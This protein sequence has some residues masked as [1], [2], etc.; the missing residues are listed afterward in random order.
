MAKK[1]GKSAVTLPS[2]EELQEL[3]LRAIVAY[4]VRAGRRVQPLFELPDKSPNRLQHMLAIDR[5]LATT[6]AFVTDQG[7]VAVEAAYAAAMDASEVDERRKGAVA[8]AF[9]VAKAAAAAVDSLLAT[10]AAAQSANYAAYAARLHGTEAMV[11]VAARQDFERLKARGLGVYPEAGQRFSLSTRS[12]LGKLWPDGEPDWYQPALRKMRKS[13]KEAAAA[14]EVEPKSPK[15]VAT[16]SPPAKK[17]DDKSDEVKSEIN[18]IWQRLEGIKGAP[19]AIADLKSVVSGLRTQLDNISSKTAIS[20]FREES[21]AALDN[22]VDKLGAVERQAAEIRN[23]ITAATSEI[24][25][26][27][28]RVSGA[29][30]N[31]NEEIR[32]EFEKSKTAMTNELSQIQGDV[33]T[34]IESH[35]QAVADQITTS[36]AHTYWATKKKFHAVGF[37]IG[38]VVTAVA[39]VGSL[40]AVWCLWMQYFS[41]DNGFHPWNMGFAAFTATVL[42]LMLR[43]LSRITI[44]NLHLATEADERVVMTKTYLAFGEYGKLSDEHRTLMLNALFRPSTTGLVKEDAVPPSMLDLATR[45]ANPVKGGSP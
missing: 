15:W 37:W 9:S 3:P 19:E 18:S 5:A 20:A 11:V 33:K 42:L 38:T 1:R 10:T 17:S 32:I 22:Q 16:A 45:M 24:A 26:L 7:V 39:A 23:S 27:N 41:T 34:Q 25:Q 21:T 14:A 40:W 43:L 35:R 31:L 30:K 8:V 36:E 28:A 4:A 12:F 44:S 2:K 29:N 13:L 6:E